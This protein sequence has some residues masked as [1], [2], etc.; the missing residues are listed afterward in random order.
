M[1]TREKELL[2]LVEQQARNVTYLQGEL[3]RLK[4]YLREVAADRDRFMGKLS[5]DSR[6]YEETIRALKKELAALTTRDR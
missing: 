2:D 4:V 1:T 6:H 5:D 3:H